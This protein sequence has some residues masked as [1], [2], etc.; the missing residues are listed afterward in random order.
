MDDQQQM[1]NRQILVVDDIRPNQLVAKLMLEQCGAVVGTASDG[2]EAVERLLEPHH[3]DLVLMDLQMPVMG[4][5]EATRQ[6][7][8]A[9]QQELPIIVVTASESEE[10]RRSALEA[11]ADE[12]I[13]KPIQLHPLCTLLTAIEARRAGKG[14]GRAVEEVSREL[15]V[16]DRERL[17]QLL[18]LLA[19]QM[20]QGALQLDLVSISDLIQQLRAVGEQVAAEDMVTVCQEMEQSIEEEDS[21]ELKSLYSELEPLVT[22]VMNDE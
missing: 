13:M 22:E 2:R 15:T 20:K 12:V 5:L 6:I 17:Q 14:E 3:Y 16:A 19:Q 7:R 4:G 1:S 18:E 11:G 21:L 10:D 9:G 8:S